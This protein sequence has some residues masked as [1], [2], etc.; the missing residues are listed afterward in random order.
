MVVYWSYQRIFDVLAA[1]ILAV[2]VT[3]GARLGIPVFLP[4]SDAAIASA[5]RTWV[6]PVLTLL[7][8]TSA[9][10]AFIF[11]VVD[12]LEFKAIKSARA[13][14]QLWQIFSEN[15]LWLSVSAI[16]AAALSFYDKENMPL[17]VRFTAFFLF[18]IDII[19]IYKFTWV[20]RQIISVRMSG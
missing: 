5:A 12:R 14:R 17:I 20:M 4:I 13:E 2:T 9:T 7:G 3:F 6:A 15:L 19:C 18:Y 8:M 1:L 11:S 16:C 10:T